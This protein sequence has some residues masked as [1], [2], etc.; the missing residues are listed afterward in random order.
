MQTRS[1]NQVVAMIPDGSSLMIGGFMGVGTS[2]RLVDEIVRQGKRNLTV[3]ANDTAKPGVGIGKLVSAKSIR[4]LIVSRIGLN[5]EA[6]QQLHIVPSTM[7][8]YGLELEISQAIETRLQRR[9]R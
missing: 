8:L 2:E 5:P 3:I 9:T 4:R 6:Q 7:D 1:L